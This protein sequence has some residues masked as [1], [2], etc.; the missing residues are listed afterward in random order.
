MFEK[1]RQSKGLIKTNSVETNDN[2]SKVGNGYFKLWW[3][4]AI[5]SYNVDGFETPESDDY[6]M[7][8]DDLDDVHRQ[9]LPESAPVQSMAS[10][11]VVDDDLPSLETLAAVA[12]EE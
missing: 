3:Q 4:N 1:R 2:G 12:E 5:R 6:P 8:M 9:Q 11:E 10:D 7:T